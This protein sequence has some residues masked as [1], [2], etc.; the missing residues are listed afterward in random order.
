M[1][2]LRALLFTGLLA[3]AAPSAYAIPFGVDIVGVG[4]GSWSLNGP[5]NLSDTWALAYSEEFDIDPGTY[6]WNISGTGVI[7]AL[8][9]LS[10]DGEVIYA[11]GDAGFRRFTI[12]DDYSFE[13]NVPEPATLSLLGLALAGLGFTLRRRVRA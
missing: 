7:F 8:W 9:F 12:R 10:L 4:G 6:T 1:N 11:N 13:T 2:K 5:T 3:L